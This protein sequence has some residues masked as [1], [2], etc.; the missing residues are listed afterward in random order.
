MDAHTS[1]GSPLA[2]NLRLKAQG[3][4]LHA[5]RLTPK[6]HLPL[7]LPCIFPA[8]DTQLSLWGLILSEEC[9]RESV[10]KEHLSRPHASSAEP[11]GS[12]GDRGRTWL[13]SLNPNPAPMLQAP[14]PRQDLELLRISRHHSLQTP[15]ATDV[16]TEAQRE[17]ELAQSHLATS[18]GFFIVFY[19]QVAP[20]CQSQFRPAF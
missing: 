10:S 12:Q 7:R 8:S 5:P 9:V 16:E 14:S 17:K 2:S 4:S 3:L 15:L 19:F 20:K 13:R 6:L 1:P 18:R 11:Q